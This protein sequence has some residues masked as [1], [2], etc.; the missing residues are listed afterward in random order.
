MKKQKAPSLAAA[1]KQAPLKVVTEEPEA[2]SSDTSPAAKREAIQR[3]KEAAVAKAKAETE[4]AQRERVELMRKELYPGGTIT[5][6]LSPLRWWVRGWL[7]EDFLGAIAAPPKAGKSFV[8]LHFAIC[9]AKGERI[10]AGLEDFP[11]PLRVLY[12][13]FEKPR[14]VRDRIAAYEQEYGP[15]PRETF[16]LYA[17]RHPLALSNEKAVA[18]FAAMLRDLQPELIIVDTLARV[19]GEYEENTVEGT[20]GI[21]EALDRIR[22]KASLFFVHHEGKDGAKGMRGSSNLLAA[23]DIVLKV[24]GVPATGLTVKV[25]ASNAAEAPLPLAYIVE[26]VLLPPEEGE[27]EKRAVGLIRETNRKETASLVGPRIVA[28]IREAFPEG[29]TRKQLFDALNKDLSPGEQPVGEKSLGAALTQLK[30]DG[31]IYYEG[32]GRATR[33]LAPPLEPE[34]ARELF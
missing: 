16:S 21:V 32:K 3:E 25:T 15:L 26:T 23:V 10:Y 20:R 14:I 29:A 17:P 2:S 6:A 11:R 27:V 28:V 24:E 5:E 19:E 18:D 9:A 4:Q 33:W 22:G 13:A 7:A 8:A 31:K 12:C 30:N 34:E 1:A